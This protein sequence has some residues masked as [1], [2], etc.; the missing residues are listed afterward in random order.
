M[1]LLDKTFEMDN[2]DE[3]S[4][5]EGYNCSI[6]QMTFIGTRNFKKHFESVHENFIGSPKNNENVISSTKLDKILA[7]N[8]TDENEKIKNINGKFSCK[9]CQ[10]EFRTITHLKRHK[11]TVHNGMRKYKC[12][13]CGKKFGQKS[14]LHRHNIYVHKGVK[15]YE[16]K[17]C[18]KTFALEYDLKLHQKGVHEGLKNYNCDSCGKT[19]FRSHELKRHKETVHEGIR[20]YRCELCNKTFVQPHVLKKHKERVHER[21]KNQKSS[22]VNLERTAQKSNEKHNSIRLEKVITEIHDNLVEVKEE[23]L[24]NY[25]NFCMKEEDETHKIYEN[26]NYVL[27]K[28]LEPTEDQILSFKSENEVFLH[29]NNMSHNK[30][31][32]QLINENENIETFD[33]YEDNFAKAPVI[34][35]IFEDHE[36]ILNET[37]QC[38]VKVKPL[39]VENETVSIIRA[40]IPIFP[41]GL[42]NYDLLDEQSPF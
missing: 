26:D 29:E 27:N 21:L 41:F 13:P 30:I 6:C 22:K 3:Q 5:D 42:E 31:F 18:D 9:T 12:I 2:S 17:S 11:E 24:E 32:H 4:F 35:V 16:C 37:I 14:H 15:N 7:N 8:A 39:E 23:I 40:N 10:K 38:F 34:G 33:T 19:F 36:K 28:T 20:N 25:E 1:E